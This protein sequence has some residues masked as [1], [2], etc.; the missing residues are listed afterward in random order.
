M[1]ADTTIHTLA[2]QGYS[3]METKTRE[4]GT[5][6]TTRKD[7]APFWLGELCHDAHGNMFPDDWRYETIR[8]ALEFIAGADA[9]LDD[10]SAEFA[11]G[12]DV[13]TTDLYA[14]LSSSFHRQ[15]YCD[16]A[17]ADGLVG[18]DADMA[19]RITLGQYVE[20]LEVFGLVL[21]SLRTVAE[22]IEDETTV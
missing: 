6:Y 20:R 17:Q 1:N 12:V 15:G 22:A 8:E 21:D 18:P 9:D 19:Q 7:D 5:E 11:D 2:A 16:D 10:L 4:D 14:W 13:Y 3:A